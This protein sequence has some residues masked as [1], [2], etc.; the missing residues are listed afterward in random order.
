MT[1]GTTHVSN[2]K[3]IVPEVIAD[4]IADKL[5]KYIKFTPLAEM[6]FTL[7]AQPGMTVVFP[8]WQYIGDAKD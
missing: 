3:A 4:G 6:D 7:Q 2:V 8:T 5:T 1:V